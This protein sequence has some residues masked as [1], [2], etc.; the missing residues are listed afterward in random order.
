MVERHV[1]NESALRAA[2]RLGRVAFDECRWQ[3]LLEECQTVDMTCE[4][5]CLIQG[6]VAALLPYHIAE[7]EAS[8]EHTA[9]R[10]GGQ[11][12]LQFVIHIDACH[13]AHAV[14]GHRVVV[15]CVIAVVAFQCELTTVGAVLQLVVLKADEELVACTLIVSCTRTVCHQRTVLLGSLEPE[16]QRVV[17]FVVALEEVCSQ[18]QALRLVCHIDIEVVVDTRHSV[19]A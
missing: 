11:L 15:P 6:W 10:V 1:G 19:A 9:E 18:L 7:E 12:C 16:H 17:L 5:I 4:G 8:A 3:C 14:H 2:R 13:V